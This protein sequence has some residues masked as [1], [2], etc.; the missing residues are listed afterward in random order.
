MCSEIEMAEWTLV[1]PQSFDS[2]ETT[3]CHLGNGL[4][5]SEVS[6][7]LFSSRLK[8]QLLVQCCRYTLF[9]TLLWC[10]TAKKKNK[11]NASKAYFRL[12]P[13]PVGI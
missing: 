13:S 2:C 1:E 5:F 11:I 6:T 9:T 7:L 3:A 12:K 10:S 8:T 4:H